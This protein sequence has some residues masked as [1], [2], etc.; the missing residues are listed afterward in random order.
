MCG[1][2]MVAISLRGGRT[3][4]VEMGIVTGGGDSS[5]E[6][7]PGPIVGLSTRGMGKGV[8]TE[9]PFEEQADRISVRRRT[10]G[11]ICSISGWR[12]LTFKSSGGSFGM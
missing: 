1:V 4:V 6:E 10:A 8:S 5:V 2:E 9:S 7:A 12:D 11:T 3:S